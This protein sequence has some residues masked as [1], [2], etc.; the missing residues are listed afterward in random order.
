[1]QVDYVR[2][3]DYYSPNADSIPHALRLAA[4]ADLTIV[5]VGTQSMLLARASQPS[6]SGEG[7]DLS[8]LTLLG[9]QQQLVD[10]L[11]ALGKPLVVVLV[12]G[13]P[14]LM[15]FPV[16]RLIMGIPRMD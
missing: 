13:R 14:F 9:V 3:C 1:M 6:T 7:Y 12:T 8:E 10:S 16:R 4:Q 11:V 15:S 5:V 2:G